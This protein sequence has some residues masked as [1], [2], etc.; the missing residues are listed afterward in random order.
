M[1]HPRLEAFD[2][3][4]DTAYTWVADVARELDSEDRRF[5]YRA[6]RSW[7]HTLRDRLPVSGA[8]ALAAQLPELIR[9]TFYEGWEPAHVPMKYGPSEYL[10]RFAQQSRVPVADAQEVAAAVTRAVGRHLSPGLLSGTLR[11]LPRNVRLLLVEA[12]E[13]PEEYAGP[14]AVEVEHDTTTYEARLSTVEDKVSNLTEALTVLARG[15]EEPPGQEPDPGRSA[16]A[17]RLAHEIL[18]ATGR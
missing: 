15:L 11:H 13:A 8:T 16:R 5:A 9:G 4:L 10:L 2:H 7:L 18:L 17:A 6:L 14:S 1:S 12:P 3:A